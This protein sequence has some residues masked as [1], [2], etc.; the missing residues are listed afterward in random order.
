VLR[1]V[2]ASLSRLSPR[3]VLG[4]NLVVASIL[5]AVALSWFGGP[6]LA[7]LSADPS[8]IGLGGFVAAV[9]AVLLVS[10]M[11]WRLLLRGVGQAPSLTALTLHGAAGQSV[12]ML[13]PSARLG[14]DAVRAYLL[15]Q[16]GV[17]APVCIATVAVDRVL[18]MGAT[19]AFAI[20]FATLLLQVGVPALGGVLVTMLVGLAGLGAG[21][22]VTARRL[23]SGRGVVTALVRSTRLDRLGSVARTLDVLHA[24]EA[25]AAELVAQRRRLAV[26]FVLGVGINLVVLVEYWFLLRAFGLP[27]DPLAVVAAIFGVGAASSMPV[28]AGVGVLE[29]SQM[30]LFS[31]LGHAPEVGL[32]V[33]LAIRL[34]MLVWVLPGLLHLAVR[35]VGRG[36][37]APR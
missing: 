4:T 5:L 32:A 24:A 10:A 37:A 3:F 35:G 31:V 13:V 17:A 33:G 15:A 26:A 20:V 1:A 19:L 9:L 6:A 36:T 29:G 7:V 25:A 21:V 23:R 16:D 18:D 34:R 28:P 12:S 14:G 8:W 11:R 30:F 22:W 2:R 27:S